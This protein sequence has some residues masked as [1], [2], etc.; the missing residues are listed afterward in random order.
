MAT[1]AKRPGLP[2]PKNV[3]MEIPFA[4]AG[5][6]SMAE[7]SPA[8]PAYRILRTVEVDQY[9]T[10]PSKLEVAQSLAPEAMVLGAQ[11]PKKKKKAKK[12]GKPKA[13][14]SDMFKGTSRKAS[15]LSVSD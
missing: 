2:N 8:A 1:S 7:I 3:V 13:S 6:L 12:P 5:V 11:K 15:K 10:P 9:E 14:S 4:P